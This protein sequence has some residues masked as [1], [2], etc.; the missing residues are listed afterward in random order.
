M[1]EL[2]LQL[3]QLRDFV[4]FS[5][6]LI[7][8]SFIEHFRWLLLELIQPVSNSMELRAFFISN[9]RLGKKT[10]KSNP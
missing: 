1:T 3:Y 6:F 7:T 4:N 8:P 5:N 10:T 9:T 2:H